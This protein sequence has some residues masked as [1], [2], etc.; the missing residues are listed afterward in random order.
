[1][2]SF[3]MRRSI[4][5]PKGPFLA[6]PE[7]VRQVDGRLAPASTE[8]FMPELVPRNCTLLTYDPVKVP[9]VRA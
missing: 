7:S 3:V 2:P 1:M 4:V 8:V 5:E 9:A 6:E